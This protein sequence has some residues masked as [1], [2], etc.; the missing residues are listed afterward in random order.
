MFFQARSSQMSQL[1]LSWSSIAEPEDSRVVIR[2]ICHGWRCGDVTLKIVDDL[3]SA[4]S[5]LPNLNAKL[6][7]KNTPSL[8]VARLAEDCDLEYQRTLE[9]LASLLADKRFENLGFIEEHS[10]H[11]HFDTIFT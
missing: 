8:A 6:E 1:K 4:M 9:S 7:N 5:V 11:L 3:R 10:Q 2:V